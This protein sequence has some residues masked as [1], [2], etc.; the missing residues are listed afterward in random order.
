[1]SHNTTPRLPQSKSYLKIVGIPYYID[2][3]NTRISSE[4]IEQILK[5]SY[6][7][8]DI[9]LASKPRIIKIS[10]KSDIAIVWINIWDNQNG[11]NTKKIINR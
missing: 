6:I 5:N 10:S 3:L 7:F 9:I 11:N 8:N 4:D 1:M 2:K